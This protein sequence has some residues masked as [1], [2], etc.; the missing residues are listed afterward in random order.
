MAKGETLPDLARMLRQLKRR[1]ARRRGGQELSYR[2]LAAKTGWSAGM[3]AH[4]FTG[5]TL[6]PTDRFDI[7][8]RLLGASPV[9]QGRLATIR[10]LIDDDRR[11]PARPGAETVRLLGPIEV[12]GPDGRASLVGSKQ[13]TLVG[14]L[15]LRVGTPV[16]HLKLAEALWG[17][18]LPR[19][20]MRSLY[21]HVARIR[22][23][24]DDCGLPGI[25]TTRES[26]YLLDLP[27]SEVDTTR[28]DERSARGRD[29]LA[30]GAAA[31]AVTHILDGLA[32]WR[33]PA[34]ED[35]EPMAWAGA[36]VDRLTQAR[37]NALED[38]WDARLRLGEHA[39][40]VTEIE[41]LL[42]GDPARERLVSLLML[43]LCR[44]GRHASA[45][46]AYER[47]RACLADELGVDPSPQLQRLHVAVLRRDPALELDGPAAATLLR[48][49]QLPPRAGHFTGRTLECSRLDGI[50]EGVGVISGPGGMGKTALAVHWAHQAIDRF[51]DGQLFLDLRGH[52]PGTA[53]P[54]A[55]ALNQLLTGLGMQGERP[56]DERGL[57]GA[58]AQLGLYRSALRERRI[59]IVLDNAGSAGQVAPLVP[60]DSA[61]LLV[62]TSRQQ[63][64]GLALDHAV[65]SIQLDMLTREDASTLLQRVLGRERVAGERDSADRLVELCGR[66]PLALRIAAA[67]LAARRMRPLAELVIELTGEDRLG[68]LTVPG[69]SHSI[70][71]VFATAYQSLSPL[72]ATLF[73]SLG[74]HPGPNFCAHLA[75]VVAGEPVQDALDEL[76]SA[77]LISEVDGDRFRFH[78]LI[79]LYAIEC[80]SP[81]ERSQTIFKIIM[82]YLAMG[83]S[84]NRLLEPARDV[85]KVEWDS[86][87]PD[88]SFLSAAETALTFLD[89]ELPNLLPIARLAAAHGHPQVT[90][91]LTYLLTG[92]YTHRGYWSDYAEIC[93]EGLAAALRLSDPVAEPL[94]RGAL[95]V[96]HNVLH[97]H[98]EAL[99]QLT[100]ARELIRAAGDKWRE[101]MAL[102][103]IAHAY[104]QLGRLDDAVT[105]FLEA[106]ELHTEGHHLPGVALAL[107][108][109]ADVYTRMGEWDQAFAHLDRALALARQ[110][111][112]HHLEGAVRQNLGETCLATGDEDRA[113]EHFAQALDIRRRTG[114]KRREAETSNAIGLV[115]LSRG[116][117]ASALENFGRALALS[118]EINDRGL[119]SAT[120]AHMA[121][122]G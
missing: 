118:R 119:E 4:Y 97:R 12:T 45:I 107:N 48:P 62:V 14:L 76:A 86:A 85:V 32:L 74:N 15:A 64:V 105:A 60:P 41:R 72:A 92:Y 34:L 75:A 110:L 27:P 95:G 40:A 33:G 3:I 36:E 22:Q 19:T 101:G 80:A 13:R 52:D 26:S 31:E 47:L 65:T 6:P 59:L 77:H 67:K 84:V 17:D 43:A 120:L 56:Q 18:Q 106:L 35:A 44:S 51:P 71:T 50:T 61:S 78:D 99:E 122:L 102:N 25:L 89:A 7:L 96:A 87:P 68:A 117:H 93:R 5:R 53:M 69:G 90:W 16:S 115:H 29:A 104:S 94:M 28:F 42:A 1:D 114:E 20:A 23:A 121:E 70:R 10:D 2:A 8:V 54:V 38:L 79:R 88:M 37:L 58:D 111:D 112:N 66:M 83:E 11:L 55:E 91:Q 82:W 30:R 98:E 103:N 81:T 49:A 21:S 73:R 57:D 116:D 113:L 39:A 9:E 108:N 109:I 24:L 63:L 100:V 46:E